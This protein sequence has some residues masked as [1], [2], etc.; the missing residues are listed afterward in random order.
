MKIYSFLFIIL[1]ILFKTGNVLSNNNIFSVNNV[2]ISKE[3]YKNK[4]K[5]INQAFHRAFDQLL[6]RILLKKDYERFSST[7]LKE[8]KELILYYQVISPEKN[9]ETDLIKI[10]VFFDKDKMH[11]FFNKK[12]VL[13]SDIINTEVVLFPL[14]KK[15]EKYFIYT[16]NYFYDNWSQKENEE[17]IQYIL[18]S[19]NIED[20]QVINTYKDNFFELDI[21]KFFKEYELENIVFLSIEMNDNVAKILINT[22]IEGKKIN[23]NLLIKNKE[24][25]N[26]ENFSNKIILNVNNI[27]ADL[28]KSQ[29]LI[30]VKTPSFLNV[31]IKI[32]NK[33]S[34]LAEFNNRIKKID[35][36]DNYYVQ[37][38]NKDYVLV[39]IRYLG[40]IDK[41]INKLKKQDI[42]LKMI[43]GKWQ[44][45][46]I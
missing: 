19:E 16:K 27:I 6:N 33:K 22:R 44:L 1:I 7:S 30:D 29:N 36:I 31:A 12:N 43:K 18:P 45:K 20:I 9:D 3:I 23:K 14:L 10:N 34:N 42:D 32:N 4:E 8:I 26:E 35:L 5:L 17:L 2:E 41:I 24:K 11:N 38:I 21:S 15:D 37:Q 25:L 40:K 46:I 13:Y 39:K 28:I